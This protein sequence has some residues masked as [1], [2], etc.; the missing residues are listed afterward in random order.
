M[1][2]EQASVALEGGGK[3]IAEAVVICRNLDQWQRFWLVC[4]RSFQT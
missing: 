3:R 1:G 4:R 2:C